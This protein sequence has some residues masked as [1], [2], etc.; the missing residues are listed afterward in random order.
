MKLLMTSL[1]AVVLFSGCDNAVNSI[2]DDLFDKDY[3]KV[4]NITNHSIEYNLRGNKF[5]YIYCPNGILKDAVAPVGLWRLDANNVVHTV[6]SELIFETDG[7][8][9][10]YHDYNISYI[11]ETVRVLMISE[12]TCL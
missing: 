3:V 5:T 6:G 2:I 12:T 9:R 1:L 4:R 8:F 7:E 11:D 10:K